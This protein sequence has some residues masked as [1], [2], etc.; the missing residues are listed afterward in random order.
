MARLLDF[1]LCAGFRG[2]GFLTGCLQL[3][4]GFVHLGLALFLKTTATEDQPDDLLRKT[5]RAFDDAPDGFDGTAVV[6]DICSPCFT[7]TTDRVSMSWFLPTLHRGASYCKHLLARIS[8]KL[9]RRNPAVS[10]SSH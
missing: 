7:N 6:P 5:D 9:V 3:I 4:R 8:G 10:T 1:G 2:F